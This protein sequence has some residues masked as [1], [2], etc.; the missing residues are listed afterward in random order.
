MSGCFSFKKLG[1]LVEFK[2]WDFITKNNDVVE[3]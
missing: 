2:L 1:V 3:N